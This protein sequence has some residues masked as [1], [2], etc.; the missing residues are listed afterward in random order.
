M[1]NENRA[2]PLRLSSGGNGDG[3]FIVHRS[4]PANIPVRAMKRAAA[5]VRHLCAWYLI[6][7]ADYSQIELHIYSAH[8]SP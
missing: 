3:T 2:R 6:V 5:F 7:S 8:L 1:I 4:E